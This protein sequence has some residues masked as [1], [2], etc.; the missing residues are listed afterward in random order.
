MYAPAGVVRVFA[1]ELPAGACVRDAVAASGLLQEFPDLSLDTLDLGVF[2]R[3]CTPDRPLHAGD[4]VEVYLPLR[5]D[6]KQARHLRVAARRKA[7]AQARSA[8]P[9]QPGATD[10]T[11]SSGK[12]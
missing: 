7:D 6:P 5:I 10:P 2:N 4:R 9:S 1:V 3:P 8:T 11:H 12:P